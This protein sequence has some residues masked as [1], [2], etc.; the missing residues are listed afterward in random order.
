M[1]IRDQEFKDGRLVRE[2]I[3]HAPD[4]EPGEDGPVGAGVPL[5]RVGVVRRMVRAVLAPF[6]G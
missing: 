2:V 5:P 6:R 3:R 4:P 1:E